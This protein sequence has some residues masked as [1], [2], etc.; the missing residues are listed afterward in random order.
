MEQVAYR[1]EGEGGSL[2]PAPCRAQLRR[3]L[4]SDAFDATDR[5]RRFL[6][7]VV[8]EALAG[9]AERIKAY[10]IAIEVFGR[11]A[12]F[13]PRTDPIVRVEAGHLRRALDRYYLSAGADDPIVITVPKGGYV[14][15]FVAREAAPEATA[16]PEAPRRRV[17]PLIGA[18]LLLALV[19]LAGLLGAL[20][21]PRAAAPAKP[22][23][24]R[25]A[26]V[27]PR[28]VAGDALDAALASGLTSELIAE[29]ARFRDIVVVAPLE[30]TAETTPGPG[31]ALDGT[32]SRDGDE[33]RVSL[34]LHRP[35]DG[36]VVWARSYAADLGTERPLAAE[37][38]IAAEA[39][40]AI[41]QPYGAIFQADAAARAER[42]ADP[43]DGYACVLAYFAFRATIDAEGY[44]TV[45][46]CV[47]RAVARLPDY[48]TAWGLRAQVAIDGRRWGFEPEADLGR[49]LADAR[50]ALLLD[51][52][53]IRATEAKMMALYLGGDFEGALR[54]GAAGVALN[55]NDTDMLGEYGYRLALHGE[56]DRGC[57][58]L[59]DALARN[60][61]PLPYFET[62]IAL[63]A[64]IDGRYAEA[65]ARIRSAVFHDVPIYHLMAAAFF[66]EAG[67]MEDARRERD[68][69]AAK[70]PALLGDLE[71]RVR[72]L[73]GRP[74]D[75]ERFAASLRRAGIGTE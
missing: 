59:A 31:Y 49:A 43:A 62:G 4:E 40:T 70:A 50:H 9:R 29:L 22:D 6:A 26:V 41:G 63:C 35:V 54:V 64:Y 69:L 52:A 61:G 57:A 39:A 20:R 3:I 16:R 2:D 27:A 44:G 15:S 19:T 58:L 37:T 45:R 23:I 17:A 13:D 12:S 7:Y 1:P 33:L 46:T 32:L 5:D 65:A 53:N 60:P 67:E 68:W 74:E 56:W 10:S 55:P 24:P 71:A 8:E 11:D 42:P 38:R 75:Y 21:W 47:E 73:A 28:V 14:P 25:V 51:P 30:E 72:P 48:A 66:A 18:I 36:T 34:N